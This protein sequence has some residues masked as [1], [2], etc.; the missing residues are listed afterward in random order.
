MNTCMTSSRTGSGGCC[1]TIPRSRPSWGSIPTTIASATARERRASST[2]RLEAAP[3]HLDEHR[4]RATRPPV[5]LWQ[6]LELESAEDM[7][8]LV[9]ELVTAGRGVLTD[10]DQQR[11]ERAGETANRAVAD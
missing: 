3:R 8:S 1:G 11:L 4:T 5:R 10:T 9:N 6:Q 7:P 2:A